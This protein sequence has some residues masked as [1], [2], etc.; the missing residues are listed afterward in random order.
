MD[1]DDKVEEGAVDQ[2]AD[3]RVSKLEGKVAEYERLLL[4]PGYLEYLAGGGRKE[5]VREA[6]AA[7]PSKEV[8]FDSM[9]NKDLVQYLFAVMKGELNK[10]VQPMA[11]DAQ[12]TEMKRQVTEAAGKYSDF[13]DYK[14]EMVR[15]ARVHPSLTADDAYFMAKGRGRRAPAR[16]SKSGAAPGGGGST[17]KQP[18]GGFEAKFAEAWKQSGMTNREG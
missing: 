6:R 14:E 7:E 11:Q 1:E 3:E 17:T 18:A 4:D 13:W 9:S 2:V 15:L 16:P 8:D 5:L 10:V 12:V